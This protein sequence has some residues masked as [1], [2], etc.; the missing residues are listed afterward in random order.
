MQHV[1]IYYLFDIL[2]GQNIQIPAHVTRDCIIFNKIRAEICG[3]VYNKTRFKSILQSIHTSCSIS[4]INSVPVGSICAFEKKNIPHVESGVQLI[5]RSDQGISHIVIQL[6]Y[7]PL[8]YSYFKLRH[9]TTFIQQELR[10]W[11]LAQKWYLPNT[12]NA[13]FI[14]K[15]IFASS[16]CENIFKHFTSSVQQLEK[17]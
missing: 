2:R 7:Q 13:D 3:N 6:K 9:F 15:K 16:F 5:I 11:I 14:L 1:V 8:C 10:I 12:Y 17:N 4:Q